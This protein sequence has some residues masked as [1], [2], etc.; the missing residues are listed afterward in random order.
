MFK[1]FETT[2]THLIELA[3]IIN[4]F[5]SEAVQLRLVELLFNSAGTATTSPVTPESAPSS[6]RSK[7][8]RKPRAKSA[9][10]GQKDDSGVTKKKA[11][12]GG[13]AVATLVKIF[14]EGYFKQPRSIG[15]IC[16]H[17]EINLARRIKPNE[18]S[19]KLGRMVRSRELSRTKN[20]DN[21]YV[22]SN[23]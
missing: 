19:G 20:S 18:I 12:S 2:K 21:Q 22:Y 16:T 9:Q 8:K 7:P 6:A 5:K 15:D 11:S 14:E 3:E 4:K 17:C 13:G 1:D 23:A 10:A